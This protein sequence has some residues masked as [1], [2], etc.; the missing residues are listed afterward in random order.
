MSPARISAP[1]VVPAFIGRGPNRP[2]PPPVPPLLPPGVSLQQIDGGPTYYAD[3]GFTNA[4]TPSSVTG[5]SWDSPAFF[6]VIDDFS[7]Y[8]SNSTSTFASLGLNTSVRC[9]AGGGSDTDMSVLRAAGIWAILDA[10]NTN[11]GSETVGWHI[12]EPDGW[13]LDAGSIVPQAQAFGAFN[14]HRLLQPSFTWNQFVFGGWADCPCGSS[15]ENAMHCNISTAAGNRTLSTPSDDVYFFAGSTSTNAFG[16]PYA[17]ANM[18]GVYPPVLTAD[19]MARGSNYGDMVDQM[20]TTWLMPPY[21]PSAPYIETEDGLVSDTGARRILPPEFN[22]AVWSTIIHG[23]RMVYYFGTTSNFGSGSTFGFNTTLQSGQSVTMFQQGQ[24]TNTQIA[25][26]ARIIN[27]PFALGYATMSPGGYMF[28]TPHLVLDNGL[29]ICAKY[30]TGGGFTNSTGTFG[31]GFY[32][33]SD[34]RG[35]ETQTNI[36]ATFTVVSNYAGAVPVI[37]NLGGPS[38]SSG[39]VTATTGGGRSVFTDTFATAYD[40]HVY[41]PIP[42]V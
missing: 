22:W 21:A 24:A 26:L 18:Y 13:N 8:P 4:A 32:I 40:V 42:V 29:E 15:M 3:N 2:S 10:E 6:P 30:Y 23:A 31:N 39:T 33:L 28:P 9:T 20:R 12:E 35:S 16:V 38:Q 25:N 17:G 41:G 14:A 37:K 34:V 19:Q 1:A 7:F 36:S 11:F 27:A 5:L